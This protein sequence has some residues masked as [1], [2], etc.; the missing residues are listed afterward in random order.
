VSD[1]EGDAWQ[2]GNKAGTPPQCNTPEVLRTLLVDPSSF[3]ATATV[4]LRNQKQPT[5]F[6]SP[7]LTSMIKLPLSPFPD[8][9]DREEGVVVE[10]LLPLK[11]VGIVLL[12]LT[13]P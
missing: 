4:R 11:S 7:P 13:T 1:V 3:A 2:V 8:D 6:V 10:V 5:Q 12:L 9:G